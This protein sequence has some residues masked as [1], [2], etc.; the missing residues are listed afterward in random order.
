MENTRIIQ[1]IDFILNHYGTEIQLF[2]TRNICGDETGRVYDENEINIDY[3]YDWDYLE[4]FG[5]TQEEKEIL[6]KIFKYAE[7]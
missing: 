2:D 1:V 3:C 4:I 5:L 6:Q 7:F